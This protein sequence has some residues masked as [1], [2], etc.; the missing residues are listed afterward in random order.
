MEWA[1]SRGRAAASQSAQTSPQKNRV[2]ARSSWRRNWSH[3]GV[4]AHS[5]S[6]PTHTHA[7]ARHS[8]CLAEWFANKAGR[9]AA[10]A[11]G[12]LGSGVT[13]HWEWHREDQGRRIIAQHSNSTYII[14]DTAFACESECVMNRSACIRMRARARPH[15]FPLPLLLLCCAVLRLF[16]QSSIASGTE[17][18][19][20]AEGGRGGHGCGGGWGRGRLVESVNRRWRQAG[21]S[22]TTVPDG[23]PRGQIASRASRPARST[24]MSKKGE[25]REGSNK[26]MSENRYGMVR[27]RWACSHK[28]VK[29][30]LFV[31]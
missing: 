10:A 15:P 29:P 25:E 31:F 17:Q 6:K 21:G 14:R 27:I 19:A 20:D 12:R 5:A 28:L 22:G 24:N 26:Q 13:H 4:V 8:E 2:R 18:D 3:L 9:A 23:P 1:N 7:H 11:G 16:S 30:W